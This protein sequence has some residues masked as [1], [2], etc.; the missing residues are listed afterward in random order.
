MA[1]TGWGAQSRR[2]VLYADEENHRRLVRDRL[3]AFGLT[4]AD[5]D[6]LRYFLRAG[7]SLGER[8]WNEWLAA[9]AQDHRADL[10]VIDT[11]S[12][13]TAGDVN[14]NSRVAQLYRDALRPATLGGAAVLLL[15]H[16]RKTNGDYP[17]N[18]SQSMLGA[19]AWASQAD[20]HIAVRATGKLTSEPTEDG[21]S[22][23]RYPVEMET[24]KVR[25]GQPALP[26]R[27]SIVSERDAENRL[28]WMA[29]EREGEAVA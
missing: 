4:N 10:V 15:H 19:R 23:Q 20:A 6:G 5:R 18:A 1:P 25:D 12:S 13:A 8:P 22:R 17:R 11:A 26:Q 24:P 21:R 7:V 9:Q 2:E 16:E 28:D 14:D 3:R 27:L 29:V